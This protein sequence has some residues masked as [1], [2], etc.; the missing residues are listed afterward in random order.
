MAD[1][2]KASSEVFADLGDVYLELGRNEAALKAY[3]RA[4]QLTPERP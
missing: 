3:E 4:E 2:P 1:S